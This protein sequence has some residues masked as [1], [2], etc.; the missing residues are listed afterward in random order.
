MKSTIF[1]YLI[2]SFLLISAS[3]AFAQTATPEPSEPLADARM[4]ASQMEAA[5]GNTGTPLAYM[6][7]QEIEGT[8][9]TFGAPGAVGGAF[10]GAI[11]SAGIYAASNK[12]NVN[13]SDLFAAAV[14][15][16]VGGAIVGASGG[17]GVAAGKA[18]DAIAVGLGGVSSIAT[19]WSSNN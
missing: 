1:T 8:E 17:M 14:G 3:S 16:A 10:V 2:A 12:G 15:G 4:T 5:F 6:S 11:V 18:V 7:Q 19:A 13:T 9:G